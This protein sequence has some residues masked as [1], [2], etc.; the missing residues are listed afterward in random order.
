MAKEMLRPGMRAPASA[1]YEVVGPDGDVSG[2]E[3]T[4][5]KGKPLPPGAVARVTYRIVDRTHNQAGLGK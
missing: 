5:V 2:K 4:G 1:Q 3:I